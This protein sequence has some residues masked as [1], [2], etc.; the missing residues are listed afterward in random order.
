MLGA[1]QTSHAVKVSSR[2]LLGS[3]RGCWEG[4]VLVVGLSGIEA[5]VQAAQQPVE[6]IALGGGVP[7]TGPTICFVVIAKAAQF[8]MQRVWYER[9][10]PRPRSNAR[11]SRGAP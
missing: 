8:A 9:A 7:V 1:V 6:Q 11:K 10:S 2:S 4:D 5:V 3:G